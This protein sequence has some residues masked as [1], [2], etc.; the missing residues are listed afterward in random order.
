VGSGSG[1]R[2]CRQ[3]LLRFRLETAQLF[4]GGCHVAVDGHDSYAYLKDALSDCQHRTQA[5]SVICFRIAG[6]QPSKLT[7]RRR[8]SHRPARRQ[9]GIAGRIGDAFELD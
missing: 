3:K 7:D 9:D 8:T 6:G 5:A 2:I 4:D 1:R